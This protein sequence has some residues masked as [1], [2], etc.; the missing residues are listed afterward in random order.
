MQ[1]TFV[2]KIPYPRRA[3]LTVECVARANISCIQL[4]SRELGQARAS[5]RYFVDY[6]N[7]WAALGLMLYARYLQASKALGINTMLKTSV[8]DYA[9]AVITYGIQLYTR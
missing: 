6:T 4:C 7:N 5:T 3:W 2:Y 8:S 1:D 9:H